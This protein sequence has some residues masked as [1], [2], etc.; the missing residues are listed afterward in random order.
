LTIE[1]RLQ[2]AGE[3]RHILHKLIHYAKVVYQNN[4]VLPKI[5]E[6]MDKET[7]RYFKDQDIFYTWF[8]EECDSSGL[9]QGD[10]S[11]RDLKARYEAY[12]KRNSGMNADDTVFGQVDSLSEPQFVAELKRKGCLVDRVNGEPSVLGIRFKVGP[13]RSVA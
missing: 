7:K 1:K 10:V 11:I 6:A 4:F 8:N 3:L 12:V 5:P 9:H 2:E 13:V